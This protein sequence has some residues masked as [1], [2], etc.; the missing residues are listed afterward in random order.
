MKII[1]GKQYE[2]TKNERTYYHEFPRNAVVKCV[3][4][5]KNDSDYFYFTGIDKHGIHTMQILYYKDVREL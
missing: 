1:V 3:G 4:Q 5:R 2:V